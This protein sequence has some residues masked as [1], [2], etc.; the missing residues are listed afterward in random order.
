MGDVPNFAKLSRPAYPTIAVPVVLLGTFA[1]LYLFNFSINTL[2]MF[3]MVLV[4]GL[5]VNDAIV[6]VENLEHV[7][8][9]KGCCFARDTQI[10]GPDS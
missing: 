10:H 3:T 8:S 7:M 5:L 1:V 4:I 6:V 2:T 9:K